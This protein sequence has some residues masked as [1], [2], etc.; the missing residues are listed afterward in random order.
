MFWLS[1]RSRNDL[2]LLY[3]FADLGHP[4]AELRAAILTRGATVPDLCVR[5]REVPGELAYP[6]WVP[7]DILGDQFVEH[8]GVTDWAGVRSAMG[9]LLGTGVD[10]TRRPWR[11]H[12]FRGIADAPMRRSPEEM[13]TV[14]VLQ[15][16]HA[17]VDGRRATAVA[18]EL[19]GGEDEF[20][21]STSV[22]G[23]ADPAGALSAH[24]WPDRLAAAV[25]ALLL[26][27][28]VARTIYHGFRSHRAREQLAALTEAG[29]VPPPGPGFAP[30]AVNDPSAPP[31]S[32][33]AVD[34]LV[35]DSDDLRVPGCTV[36]VVVLTA[37]SIAL[38]TYL[39]ARGRP[40]TGLGAQVPMALPDGGKG[41]ARNNYRNLSIDLCLDEPDLPARADKIA[42][43]LRARSERARHPLLAAQDRVTAV[44][45]ALF[46]RRDAEGWPLDTV[47]DAI[48]G[49]T[50]VSSVNRGPADLDFGGPARFSAGF[51]AVGSVMR[52]TH[53]VHGLGETVTVSLHAD[54]AVVPDLEV[55]AGYL[56]DALYQAVAA[57]R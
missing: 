33:H 24:P 22:P 34:M 54:P 19:F 30:T 42:T 10:A 18:R 44:T 50:V 37:M 47:P 41:A 4:T 56:R 3:A 29:R 57:L 2:F 12:V 35:F 25:G 53:G 7:C 9:E 5:L 16:S 43:A 55:Y 39:G 8:T 21:S 52:L 27:V 23:H 13:T 1:R 38:P 15:M 49:N 6:S 20:G 48:A 32:A 46:L 28:G 36:T 45:P 40:V 26:P 14:A 11:L 51:P 17:L 31:V